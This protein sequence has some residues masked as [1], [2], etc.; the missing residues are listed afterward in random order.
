MK[1]LETMK[2]L[3]SLFD[4]SVH[5]ALE[6]LAEGAEYI[7]VYENHDFWSSRL[8]ERTAVKVG[9]G[10]TYAS[11]EMAMKHSPTYADVPIAYLKVGS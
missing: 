4:V 7:V 6:R 1:K 9:P 10:C 5:K 11:L 2:D 8:G 3:K